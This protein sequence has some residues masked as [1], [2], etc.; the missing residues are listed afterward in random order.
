MN[1]FCARNFQWT[2][3]TLRQPNFWCSL[4]TRDAITKMVRIVV[5]YSS[6]FV[7]AVL[8]CSKRPR[9]RPKKEAKELMRGCC[10]RASDCVVFLSMCIKY[11]AYSIFGLICY[12]SYGPEGGRASRRGAELTRLSQIISSQANSSTSSAAAGRDPI[13]KMC[14]YVLIY[15]SAPL[16]HIVEPMGPNQYQ[17][18]QPTIMLIIIKI[19]CC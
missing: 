15:I 1:P 3:P 11:V 13:H 9:A 17:T 4:V 7:V 16:I 5:V 6:P 19:S 10:C 14:M 12:G 2:G 18:Q 8:I